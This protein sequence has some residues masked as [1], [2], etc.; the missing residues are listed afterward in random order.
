M[1]GIMGVQAVATVDVFELRDHLSSVD[2]GDITADVDHLFQL[3]LGT[4]EDRLC[5]HVLLTPFGPLI[6]CTLEFRKYLIEMGMRVH[7]GCCLM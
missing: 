4:I 5:K 2:V 6:E 1:T 7:K 3:A